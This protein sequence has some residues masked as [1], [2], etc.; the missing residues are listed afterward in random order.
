MMTR[1]IAGHVE[2][3]DACTCSEMG[4]LTLPASEAED[5]N[6]SAD[7]Q[8]INRLSARHLSREQRI[9]RFQEVIGV[10]GTDQACMKKALGQD[11][12]DPDD[13]VVL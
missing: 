13:L 10:C 3:K 1:H 4:S 2:M 8:Q 11:D 7:V 9:Q 5:C 6:D 12:G